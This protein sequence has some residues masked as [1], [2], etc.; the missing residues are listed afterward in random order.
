MQQYTA[1]HQRAAAA[2]GRRT[3]AIWRPFK[4][5]TARIAP[6]PK[7]NLA[8]QMLQS[9]QPGVSRDPVWKFCLLR[10]IALLNRMPDLKSSYSKMPSFCVNSI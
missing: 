1:E 7:L 8:I 2:K 5:V 6:S 3:S 4:T 10:E 9:L